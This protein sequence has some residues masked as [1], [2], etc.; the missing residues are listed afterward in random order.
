MKKQAGVTTNL[1][2]ILVCV[3]AAVALLIWILTHV[4]VAPHA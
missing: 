1:W 2:I 4:T 3:L